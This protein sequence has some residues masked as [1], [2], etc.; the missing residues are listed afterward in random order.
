M[1]EKEELVTLQKADK[2][3]IK[4]IKKSLCFEPLKNE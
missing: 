1:S 4:K 3:Y 2:N